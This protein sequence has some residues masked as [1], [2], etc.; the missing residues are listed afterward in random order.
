MNPIVV[1]GKKIARLIIENLKEKP[2]PQGFLALFLSPQDG[3]AQSFIKK[4]EQVA[5]ELG[6]EVRK[7]AVSEIDTNDS[8]R[9][10]V[11]KISAKK[12]CIGVVLQ[13]PLPTG[14][15]VSYIANAIPPRKDID[16]LGAQNLGKFLQGK[17][18]VIPPAV[19]VVQHIYETYKKDICMSASAIVVGQGKLI[20]RPISTWLTG[21]ISSLAV[22]D[23]GF[24]QEDIKK[25]NLVILGTGV[26]KLITGKDICQGGWVIDFG[27]KRTEEGKLIGDFDYMHDPIDH[28][29]LY[30]PTP[31]GT[32]PILVASLFEN[33]F[34]SS[35]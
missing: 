35:L 29:A 11:Q 9:E 22:V 10:R 19:R 16:C 1:D 7:Y 25:N 17:E 15:D 33:I 14:C 34:S 12:R 21:K 2:T 24:S 20:G 26:G 6:I 5:Q 13:L 27:Y 8:L 18:I 23:K 3:A 30:T 32:G 31:G 28:V 4:K